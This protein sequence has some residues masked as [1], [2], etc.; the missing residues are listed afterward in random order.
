MG[1]V[2][3]LIVLVVTG[4][5]LYLLQLVPIDATVKTVIRVVVIAVLVIYCVLFLASL[6]GLPAPGCCF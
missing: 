1:I 6:L 3:L 4:A 5:A 2:T